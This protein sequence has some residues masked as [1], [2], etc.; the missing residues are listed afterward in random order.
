MTHGST[1]RS[2]TVSKDNDNFAFVFAFFSGIFGLILGGFVVMM[3]H[4]DVK[5]RLR[6]EYTKIVECQ[7]ELPR[8]QHCVLIAVPEEKND[9]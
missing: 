1:N 6:K 9:E 7:A 3:L 8:N 4:T 2:E 5:D